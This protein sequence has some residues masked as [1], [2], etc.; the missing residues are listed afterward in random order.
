[1]TT[2]SPQEHREFVQAAWRAASPDL[3]ARY[4]E[5]LHGDQATIDDIRKA[6]EMAARATGSDAEKKVD[7]HANLQVVQITFTG[8]PAGGGPA[9]SIAVLG[10]PAEVGPGLPGG[11]E[12]HAPEAG[13]EGSL[14]IPW[15]FPGDG[16]AD[17]EPVM[18]PTKKALTQEELDGAASEIDRLLA[19]GDID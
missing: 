18:P 13:A 2:L 11:E 10:E 1:M 7:P 17:A 16:P 14:T 15:P 5:M 9:T 19:M 3:L 4:V 8:T 6:L 12:S